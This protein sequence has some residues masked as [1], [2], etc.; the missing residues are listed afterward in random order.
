[1]KY[2]QTHNENMYYYSPNWE[3]NKNVLWYYMHL[4]E[5]QNECDKEQKQKLNTMNECCV[6]IRL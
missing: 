6:C 1:M 5:T 2:T 4:M 3:E